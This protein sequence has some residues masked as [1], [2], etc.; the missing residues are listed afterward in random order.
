MRT[1]GRKEKSITRYLA[2]SLCSL[3]GYNNSVI[4]SPTTVR[5]IEAVEQVQRR[6][7]KRLPGLRN[8]SYDKHL[9]YLYPVWN[10]DI[11]MLTYSGAIKLCLV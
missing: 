6:Y 1:N 4:W 7:T 3:G 10:Y 2:S 11:Y 5:D 8:M 9:K